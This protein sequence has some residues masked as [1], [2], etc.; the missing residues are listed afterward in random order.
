MKNL[1]LRTLCAVIAAGTLQLEAAPLE[2]KSRSLD[3]KLTEPGI[4]FFAS[5]DILN[6]EL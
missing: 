3:E 2:Y 4:R 5:F 1:V 6:S